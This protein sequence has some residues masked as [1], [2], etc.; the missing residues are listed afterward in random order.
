MW[1]YWM[2][3]LVLKRG[4]FP[5][6][7]RTHLWSQTSWS[8]LTTPYPGSTH[9]QLT[10]LTS[11]NLHPHTQWIAL[12]FWCF[13]LFARECLAWYKSN[14]TSRVYTVTLNHRF[15]IRES[16]SMT[17]DSLSSLTS[18]MYSKSDAWDGFMD[19]DDT[20]TNPTFKI[21]LSQD[22]MTHTC[23]SLPWTH[24]SLVTVPR[25]KS[26]HSLPHRDKRER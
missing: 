6:T 17:I 25:D 26:H 10:N 2:Y 8:I 15:S 18:C 11:N 5:H 7:A 14:V 13:C 3:C 16:L 24:I 9:L 23:L 22:N 1:Y 19:H 21:K 12:M 4:C 20:R